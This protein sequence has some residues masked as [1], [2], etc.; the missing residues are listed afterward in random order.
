MELS[1]IVPLYNEASTLEKNCL[2]IYHYLKKN[3]SSFEII[4]VNDGSQDATQIIAEKLSEHHAEIELVH[5]S[6][7][8]GKGYA[9]S[10]G[11]QAAQGDLILFLDVDLSTP[12]SDL[13]ILKPYSEQSDVVI[14]SRALASSHVAK[15][16]VWYRVI[17]GRVGNVLIQ[18]LLVPGIQDTQC[19]FKLF[20]N[21]AAKKLFSQ[22]TIHR[23]GFDFEIL[24]LAKKAGYAIKE[25]GVHWRDEDESK[26][27]F[28]D[29]FSTLFE[30]VKIKWN[31]LCGRYKDLHS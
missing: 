22:L 25:V 8:Q 24:Y 21:E 23:W 26:L 29:Y 6:D 13:A 2:Q 5:Y 3:F 19:G 27:K 18:S 14:G 30:L 28:S 31:N 7:N 15:K 16:Q 4:L 12:I 17:L 10:R 11:V 1:V 9:I 20:R